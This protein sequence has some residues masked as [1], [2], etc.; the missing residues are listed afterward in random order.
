MFVRYRTFDCAE[1]TTAIKTGFQ[2]GILVVGVTPDSS[3]MLAA[4]AA[5]EPSPVSRSNQGRESI[6]D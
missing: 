6:I 3:P 4:P 1:S 5:T 2:L